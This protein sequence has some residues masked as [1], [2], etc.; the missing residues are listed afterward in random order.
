MF[1]ISLM[2]VSLYLRTICSLYFKQVTIANDP[3]RVIRMM[4][5]SDAS[6]WSVTYGHQLSNM[7]LEN[8]HS[9]GVTHGNCHVMIKIFIKGQAIGGKNYNLFLLTLWKKRQVTKVI[10][11]QWCLAC[12]VHRDRTRASTLW[13]FC[14]FFSSFED[15][16]TCW[17]WAPT[18]LKT[19]QK[20]WYSHI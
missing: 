11:L 20:V 4:I 10:F 6:A 18:T 8:T 7:H 1:S 19:H 17:L 2:S 9:T 3:S 12:A 15:A 13:F 5:V 16:K 14:L